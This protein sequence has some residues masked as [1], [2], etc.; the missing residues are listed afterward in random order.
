MNE[1]FVVV[2]SDV[3]PE[4][5]LKVIE[6]KRLLAHGVCKTSTEACQVTGISRSAYYKYKDTAFSYSKEVTSSLVT[7]YF[8][9]KDVAGV[10][11]DVFACFYKNGANVLTINQNIPIDS[12]ATATITVRFEDGEADYEQVRAKLAELSGVINVTIAY[13]K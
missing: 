5:I 9:L 6:A 2:R 10:Y 7:Y 4:I 3:L 11:S 8:T 12:V 13:G 1:K